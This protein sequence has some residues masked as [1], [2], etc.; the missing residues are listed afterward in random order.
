MTTLK[1][2]IADGEKALTD[3][4]NARLDVEL[5][6]AH[7]ISQ[8]RTWL[9]TWPDHI[10]SAVERNLY[11]E[12]LRRRQSG[13]PIAY[14][15]G[16]QA[17]WNLELNITP[18]VLIPRPETELLVEKTLEKLAGIKQARVVDLGTGSGA[19]ALALANDNPDW[20]I[21]GS[22]SSNEALDV[23]RNNAEFLDISNVSFQ[24]GD[25]LAPFPE[26]R[27]HAIV[28]NPPYIETGDA[29]LDQ[30]DVRF[31][32]E[33]ALISGADGLEDIRK[34]AAQ[35]PGQ[36]ENRGWLLLEHGYNQGEAARKIFTYN[37]F[38]EIETYKD[39]SGHERV[40]AGQR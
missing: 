37:G 31:E 15:V 8:T 13:E 27:F 18:D 6:L 14:L 26:S 33:Q 11:L 21:S 16:K 34:I 17:F 10:P 30:G 20:E 9:Y 7:S 19:I 28:S 38:R 35:S 25:W 4:D 24:A 22:D 40:T 23:A 5:L 32:P 12:L 39:L 2:L 29:H 3:S 1:Q 36:L